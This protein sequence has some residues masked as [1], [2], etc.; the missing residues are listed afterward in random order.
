MASLVWDRA[1]GHPIER[2]DSL[3]T[4]NIKAKIAASKA[5]A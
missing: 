3:T 4:E 1:L 2:P 5:K